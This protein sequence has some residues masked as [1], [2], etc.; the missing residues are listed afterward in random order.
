LRPVDDEHERD[1]QRQPL[2][3][4]TPEDQAANGAASHRRSNV[5]RSSVGGV[6]SGGDA[7]LGQARLCSRVRVAELRKAHQNGSNKQTCGQDGACRPD[8]PRDD[9]PVVRQAR[10]GSRVIT[11]VH[12]CRRIWP[13]HA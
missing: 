8:R 12:L 13:A 7:K 11:N 2:G 5:E 4:R 1:E 6:D 9:E 3:G 10:R